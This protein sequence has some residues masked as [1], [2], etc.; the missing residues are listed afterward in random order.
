MSSATATERPHGYAKYKLEGCRCNTCGW[1]VSEYTRVR[2]ERIA[3][4]TWRLDSAPVRVHIRALGAA[5]MGYKRVAAVA[6]IS[7]ST[8]GRVL[9]G[10]HD[11]GTPPPATIRYDLG[12]KLLAVEPD[13]HPNSSIEASGTARR[14]QALVAI[15]HTITAV[16]HEIGWTLQNLSSLAHSGS[17]PLAARVEVRTAQAVSRL[18]DRWSMVVPQG[19]QADRARGHARRLGWVPPLAWDD[20]E[21]DDPFASPAEAAGS[22]CLWPGC[23]VPAGRVKDICDTHYQQRRRAA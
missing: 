13:L 18:Y 1:A 2:A 5:G 23:G 6:G 11:K 10:R 4:G 21:I 16:A 20:E 19:V 7:V 22:R 15:G 12:T 8:V 9:Y 17:I 3:A 14:I